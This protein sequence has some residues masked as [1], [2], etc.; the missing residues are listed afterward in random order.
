MCGEK[1]SSL[2]RANISSPNFPGSYPPHLDCRWEIGGEEGIRVR[3]NLFFINL[4]QN[5]DVL[6]VYDGCCGNQSGLV[7]E[8]T[9]NEVRV[10]GG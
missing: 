4:E 1:G 7:R 6:R 9:G 8:F 5:Y 10:L 2:G 3:L